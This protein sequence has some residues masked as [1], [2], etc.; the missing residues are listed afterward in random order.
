[1][2]RLCNNNTLEVWERSTP[3]F[4]PDPDEIPAYDL[5]AIEVAVQQNG[6]ET[7]PLQALWVPRAATSPD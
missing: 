2:Q 4:V 6:C 7:A 3:V 5:T 1:M